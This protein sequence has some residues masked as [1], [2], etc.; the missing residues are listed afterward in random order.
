MPVA[1]SRGH[2]G[3]AL[4][5]AGVG[6]V[7]ARGIAFL[8]A[9]MASRGDVEIRLGADRFFVKPVILDELCDTLEALLRARVAGEVDHRGA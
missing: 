8:V 2:A 1:Q 9:Q 4:L 6:L 3:K 5:V 7:V